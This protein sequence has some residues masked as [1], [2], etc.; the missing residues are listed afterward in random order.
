MIVI[1]MD[2]PKNCNECPLFDDR[3]DY[4]T[5]YVNR[6]SSGYNFPIFEKRMDFCPIKCNLDDIKTETKEEI[7]DYD[8]EEDEF[9]MGIRCGLRKANGFIDK[10]IGEKT[11][12][13]NRSN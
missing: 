13:T 5:C 1:D 8:G 7:R 9:S 4:P 11:N 3:W 6:L 2:M 10:H 12:G